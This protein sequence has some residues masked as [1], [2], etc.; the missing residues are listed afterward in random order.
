MSRANRGR[1]WE[2]TLTLQHDAYRRDRAA[3]IF[4]CHP[5]VTVE[6]ELRGGKFRGFFAGDGPPDFTGYLCDTGRAVC[7]DAK[8]AA[9]P[10][11]E[12]KNIKRHQARDLTA[13]GPLGLAF[14]ALRM[15]RAEW[16]LPWEQLGPLWWRWHDGDAAHGEASLSHDDCGRIGWRMPRPGDWLAAL[17]EV[18]RHG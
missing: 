6:S 14:I 7:F 3:V 1:A 16:V 10:R 8:S 2:A 5:Q 11:F 13:I 4:R 9:G 15:G 17:P 12:L 18:E